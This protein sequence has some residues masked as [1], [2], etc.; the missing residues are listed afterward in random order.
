MARLSGVRHADRLLD[1]AGLTDDELAK[2]AETH[3]VF[4]R[5][6]PE[7]KKVLI[8]ALQ[9]QGHKVAMT[10]DAAKQAAQLVLLDSDFAVLRDVI[11]EEHRV[12]NN[13]TKSAEVFFI[14]TIY[15]VLLSVLCLLLNVDF[16]FI[17]I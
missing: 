11:S 8:S 4:G 17:P 15:S 3:T 9:K 16:P 1:A 14:K 6:T 2:A 13:L 5:V 7:Q 10:G 12:I